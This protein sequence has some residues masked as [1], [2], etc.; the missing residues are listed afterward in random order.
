[1]SEKYLPTTT[2]LS[3]IIIVLM[4]IAS[5]GG[6]LLDNLYRDNVLVTSGWFGNDL[7]TLFVA[8]P[9]LAAAVLLGRRGSWR[10]YLIWMGMLDYTLYNFGFYLFGSA[11]NSFFLIYTALFTLSAF[12]LLFGLAACD[13]QALAR[14][15]KASAPARWIA[16]WMA[17][18]ALFL[19]AF[20]VAQSLGYV[21][22][23][24][25]PAIMTSVEWPTNVTAALDLSL[26]VS[27]N[28]L[29]ALW[30]WRGNPWGIVAAGIAN[31][32]GAVYMLA[33]A[34]TTVAAFE[35]GAADS[36]ALAGLW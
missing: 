31:V 13:V 5:G 24:E 21:F 3:V 7:V 4:A 19:G 15:V 35:A 28:A 2:V 32:K 9:L 8:T 22:T 29:G 11:L 27:I 16:G 25:V 14:H 17:V 1:M 30:L 6:L 34:A 23:G 12:A 20:W 33:L 10:A 18:V 26:V 36:M